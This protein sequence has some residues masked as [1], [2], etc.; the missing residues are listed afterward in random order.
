MSTNHFNQ[1]TEQEAELL[2]ILAEECGE[3]VQVV[4]KILR[5]GYESYSPFD[6]N[7]TTNRKLLEKELGDVDE[8]IGRLHDSKSVQVKNIIE[9]THIKHKQLKVFTHHQPDSNYHGGL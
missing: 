6:S 2:A 3:V 8:I 9:H 5:H 7:K 1:L 4:G